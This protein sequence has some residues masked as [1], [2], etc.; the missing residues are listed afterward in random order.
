LPFD[1]PALGLLLLAVIPWLS[2]M[3]KS[4]EVSGIAKVELTDLKKKVDRVDEKFEDKITRLR[5]QIDLETATARNGIQEDIKSAQQGVDAMIAGLKT[6]TDKLKSETVQLGAEMRTEIEKFAEVAVTAKAAALNKQEGES[7]KAKEAKVAKEAENRETVVY[8][9]EDPQ[10]K[11]WGEKAE[12]E[13]RKLSATIRPVPDDEYLHLISLKVESKNAAKP[14]T[15]TVRFHV[16][17]T[18]V[19]P[20]PVV[21]VIDGTATLDLVAWGVFTVG[22]ETDDGAVP[23]ELDLKTVP[24]GK[25]D[26]YTR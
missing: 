5:E 4:F 23:L 11:R 22:A 20:D 6:Q 10:K 7:S 18:F 8:D 12:S 3:I 15:G 21:N 9:P 25:G 2:P 19:E 26:F 14:L 16:H 13:D 24:G 1:F 17:P